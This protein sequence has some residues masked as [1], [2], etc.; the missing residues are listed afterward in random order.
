MLC[1]CARECRP[2]GHR[3]SHRTA[4]RRHDDAPRT[5]ICLQPETRHR[6]LLAAFRALAATR[7]LLRFFGEKTKRQRHWRL[8]GR[9]EGHPTS[10]TRR[11][12]VRMKRPRRPCLAS[13]PH[14]Q[15]PVASRQPEMRSLHVN[16]APCCQ[17]FKTAA[18]ASPLHGL[19]N[20]V[21]RAELLDSRRLAAT[22]DHLASRR[23]THAM[24][25]SPAPL[26]LAH[27]LALPFTPL[28]TTTIL[29]YFARTTCVHK[30]DRHMGWGV[31]ARRATHSL[32]LP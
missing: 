6:V 23:A 16:R 17:R 13:P 15:S 27:S 4:A 24:P 29:L 2:L 12:L 26:S 28:T 22:G 25:L 31:Q 7:A 21:G 8:T 5:A 1:D 18:A 30:T 19:M 14:R 9:R 32:L 10:A 11:E 20:G 3:L